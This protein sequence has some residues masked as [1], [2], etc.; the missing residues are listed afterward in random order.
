ME[1]HPE[2]KIVNV[3]EEQSWGHREKARG[4]EKTGWGAS[5]SNMASLSNIPTPLGDQGQNQEKRAPACSNPNPSPTGPFIQFLLVEKMSAG[6]LPCS[7]HGVPADCTVIIIDSQ[8]LWSCNRKP[9]KHKTGPVRF[10]HTHIYVH[11][12]IYFTFVMAQLERNSDQESE[13]FS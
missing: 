8:L 5:I 4:K 13:E 11:H 10:R 7:L 9:V 3:G 1:S 6:Q 12:F 2:I